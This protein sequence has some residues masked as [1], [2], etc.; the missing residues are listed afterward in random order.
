MYCSALLVV[1]VKSTMEDQKH[2]SLASSPGSLDPDDNWQYLAD[3]E[4]L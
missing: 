3:T 2:F 4:K 1:L